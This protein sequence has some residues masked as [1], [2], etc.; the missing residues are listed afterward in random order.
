MARLARSL[1]EEPATVLR[2]EAFPENQNKE[3]SIMSSTYI[4]Y[5]GPH[6]LDLTALQDKLVDL[7]EGGMQGLRPD[8]SGFQQMALSLAEAM[9]QHGAA[10]G[11]P[12]DAYDHFV[13]CNQ[14]IETIDERL[15][16]AAKQVEVLRESR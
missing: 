7:E 2:R 9:P 1:I 13:M 12:Q 6:A 3:L 10:A 11:I 5:I 4:K 14:T 16:V 15:A 8:Q